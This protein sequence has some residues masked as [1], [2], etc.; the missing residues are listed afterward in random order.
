M[1]EELIGRVS[2]WY[3]KISVIGV[4]L[5]GPLA[6]GDTIRIRGHTTDF[7]QPVTSMQIWH[8]DVTEAKA[9]DE[10]G[11]RVAHRARVGDRVYKVKQAE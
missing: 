5:T 6:V 11:I 10:V 1:E 7:E 8:Q 2:H 4:T 9:G 3:G